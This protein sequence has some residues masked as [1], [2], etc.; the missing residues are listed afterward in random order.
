MEIDFTN[1]QGGAVKRLVWS[2]DLH[3]DAADREKYRQFV[4]L[5][6]NQ[7][8]DI[9]LIGGDICNG[10]TSLTY[11]MGLS[12]LIKKPFYFVLGN[13][14]FYH[15]SISHIREQAKRV[16]HSNHN[17]YYLSDC[18]VIELSKSTALIGHDGWSD[19][20]AG[21]FLTSDVILNDYV[22][23]EE[24]KRLNQEERRLKLNELGTEA[25]EYLQKQLK[26]A[27]EKYERV[28]LLT[29]VPP[30]EKACVYEGVQSDANWSPHFVCKAAGVAIAELMKNYPEKHL[31]VLCGHSHS[32]HEVKI[33]PNLH[34]VTGA[35]E[36]GMPTVQ[37]LILVN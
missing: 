1:G 30:F 8:P 13:H 10:I 21:D 35:S 26:V 37:G 9:V 25:A 36:L 14:D 34:V 3:L 22:L 32:G 12:S 33:L 18:G 11:L 2:T 24:L 6:S 17:L 31:L 15:G 20:R 23:I 4:I 16:S 29:H 28:I 5:L 27:L 7:K 19:A